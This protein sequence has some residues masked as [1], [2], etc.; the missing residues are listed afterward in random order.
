MDGLRED[1]V[2]WGNLNNFQFSASF[3]KKRRE[4]V[5]YFEREF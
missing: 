2:E 5:D 1:T 3:C 4:I